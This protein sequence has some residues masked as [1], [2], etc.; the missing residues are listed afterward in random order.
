MT[1]SSAGT[2]SEGFNQSVRLRTQQ[3]AEDVAKPREVVEGIADLYLAEY[4]ARQRAARA[5]EEQD[6]KSGKVI[7]K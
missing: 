7:W 4:E 1:T 2:S 5:K 6:I 3:A